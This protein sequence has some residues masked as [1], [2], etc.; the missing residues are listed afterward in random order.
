M[1]SSKKCTFK[2]SLRKVSICLRPRTPVLAICTNDLYDSVRDVFDACRYIT[3]ASGRGLG[4]G[5]ESFLGPV[6]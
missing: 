6:N 2:G 4:P 1:S 3:R 5:I